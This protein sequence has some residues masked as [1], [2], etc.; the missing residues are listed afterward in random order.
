MQGND[1]ESMA[2][3]TGMTVAITDREQVIAAAGKKKAN[4]G[5]ADI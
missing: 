2:A 1:A 5:K 3:N 4:S